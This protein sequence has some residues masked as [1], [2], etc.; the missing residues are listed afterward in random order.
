MKFTK[1]FFKLNNR[2]YLDMDDYQERGFDF[3]DLEMVDGADVFLDELSGWA[4]EITCTFSDEP[5]DGDVQ[6][7]KKVEEDENGA[8]YECTDGL[9][10]WLCPVAK[11]YFKDY[12]DELY[13]VKRGRDYEIDGK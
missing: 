11:Y 1:R 10:V 8:T 5:L 7:L 4:E 9:R 3:E 6:Y 2:W 13:I 12:P